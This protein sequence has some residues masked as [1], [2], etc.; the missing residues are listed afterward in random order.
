MTSRMQDPTPDETGVTTMATR[1]GAPRLKPG[2]K[3]AG[4]VTPCATCGEAKN[5]GRAECGRCRVA[6]YRSDPQKAERSRASARAYKE[7]QK[8]FANQME[9]AGR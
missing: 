5:D 6:R 1:S 2:P 8:A 3:P 4:H 7:R 9:R